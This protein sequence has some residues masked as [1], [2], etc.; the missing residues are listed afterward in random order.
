MRYLIVSI[1]ALVSAGAV[2]MSASQDTG[3][4]KVFTN[5]GRAGVFIEGNYLGPVANFGWS[6]TYKVPAGEHEIKL[7]EPRYEDLV[8][9]VTIT[10]GRLTT[11]SQKMTALPPAK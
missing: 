1:V 5:T 11:I 9:S 4:L 3:K 2:T 8:K 10:P 6:L 7:S